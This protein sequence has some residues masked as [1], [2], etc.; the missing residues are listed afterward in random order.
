MTKTLLKKPLLVNC[1][2]CSQ[3]LVVKF[4]PGQGKY[5]VKNN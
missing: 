3:S 1:F 4:N 2:K 5:I